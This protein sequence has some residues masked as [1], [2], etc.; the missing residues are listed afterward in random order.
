[1]V[2]PRT[3]GLI[4]LQAFLDAV[5]TLAFFWVALLLFV[6]LRPTTPLDY[7]QYMDRYLVY[8]F[9][10][11]AAVMFHGARSVY[12]NPW[13]G[14]P[15]LRDSHNISLTQVINVMVVISFFL[16]ATKDKAI[17]RVFLF[18][19]LVLLYFV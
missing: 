2:A 7:P 11:F 4:Y 17:S 12:Q 10:G 13:W 9:L 3:R 16:V 6:L 18:S 19:W 15:N 8:S 5:I 1:M 14:S